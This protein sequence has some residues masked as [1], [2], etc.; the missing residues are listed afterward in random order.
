MQEFEFKGSK[1]QIKK[2]DT[3]VPIVVTINSSTGTV[4]KVD[5]KINFMT[6]ECIV[7][8]NDSEWAEAVADK[9]F[10]FINNRDSVDANMYATS[11]DQPDYKADVV[12][13][14]KRNEH[15]RLVAVPI[16]NVRLQP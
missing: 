4:H 3:Y 7:D 1:Y 6:G 8:T 12:K 14:V 16:L 2:V 15:V 11:N 9:V 13:S 5:A 10:P